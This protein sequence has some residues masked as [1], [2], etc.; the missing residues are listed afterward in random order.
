MNPGWM[1]V[2]AAVTAVSAQTTPASGAPEARPAEQ[3]YSNA[4]LHLTFSYPPELK[5][6]DRKLMAEHSDAGNLGTKPLTSQACSKVLLSV[7][8]ASGSDVGMPAAS[9]TIFDIDPTCV[10]AKA[11]RNR[12]LMQQILSGLSTDG[13]TMLG[14]APVDQPVGYAIE[15]HP[16]SFAEAQGQPVAKTDLQPKDEEHT[17]AVLAV[18]VSGHILTW[19]ID[20]ND[21]QYFD[22]LLS[23]RVDFGMGTPQPLF[24]LRL[25]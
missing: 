25:H 17:M 21:Q 6:L 2:L 24:P 16:A 22:R 12:K 9:I 15:G 18:A 8:K 14:M 10:P 4:E 7:G 20:S 19:N 1:A 13:T 11:L 3:V 5:H 23:S